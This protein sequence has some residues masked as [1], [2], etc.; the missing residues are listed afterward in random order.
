MAG[1]SPFYNGQTAWP[2]AGRLTAGQCGPPSGCCAA[3]N[4]HISNV[5]AYNYN[6]GDQP[7]QFTGGDSSQGPAFRM[8]TSTVALP[9]S[10]SRHLAKR[11]TR[12]PSR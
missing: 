9:G 1:T 5:F 2:G 7:F 4:P 3:D 12:P 10:T 6:R 11:A 8:L